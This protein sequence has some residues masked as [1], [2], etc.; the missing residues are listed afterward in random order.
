MWRISK[1]N[2]LFLDVLCFFVMDIKIWV[3][4]VRWCKT[5]MMEI[6]WALK[7][8]CA[9]IIGWKFVLK[10]IN[11][12]LCKWKINV[13]LSQWFIHC[14]SKTFFYVKKISRLATAVRV[15]SYNTWHAGGGSTKCQVNYFLPLKNWFFVFWWRGRGL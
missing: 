9:W 5:V 3:K 6:K 4:I 15:D 10:K 13:I 8:P 14:S 11:Y 12:Y 1:E 7:T 2:Q